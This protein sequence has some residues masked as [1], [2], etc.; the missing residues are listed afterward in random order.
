MVNLSWKRRV[1]TLAYFISLGESIFFL[2]PHCIYQQILQHTSITVRVKHVR[3]SLSTSVVRLWETSQFRWIDSREQVSSDSRWWLKRPLCLWR[4]CPLLKTW[5]D[6]NAKA[7][8]VVVVTHSLPVLRRNTI[9]VLLVTRQSLPHGR[10]QRAGRNQ[11][12]LLSPRVFRL[13]YCIYIALFIITYFL[14]VKRF[15]LSIRD[16]ILVTV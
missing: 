7:M 10:H 3:I 11:T 16:I 6:E 9:R 15:S 2:I 14:C 5:P 12:K 1:K 8:C 4:R 13:N